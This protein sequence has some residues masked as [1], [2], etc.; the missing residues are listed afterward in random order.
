MSKDSGIVPK[1]VLDVRI[2]TV[3][4][5]I[6]NLLATKKKKKKKRVFRKMFCGVQ[7]VGFILL[8]IGFDIPFV[9][10]II[11]F[12]HHKRVLN[13]FLPCDHGF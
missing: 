2:I 6:K 4:L 13:F 11:N 10:S 1:T 3:A 5:L 7:A 12:I 8:V 9:R